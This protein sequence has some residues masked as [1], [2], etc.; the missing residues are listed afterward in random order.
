MDL[1]QL[2]KLRELCKDEAAFERLKQILAA[3]LDSPFVAITQALTQTQQQL[4][5]QQ[6]LARVIGRIRENLE[7]ETIFQIST[8]E[9]CQLLTAD[10][11]AVYRFNPD[12]SGDFVAEYVMPGWSPLVAPEIQK[13]WQDTYLQETKGGRYAQQGTF[14]V[15]NVYQAGL[16]DCHVA[17]LEQFQAKA[18]AIVPIFV[19]Q[20]LWGLLAAYQNSR[21]R[22][23]DLDEVTLLVQLGEQFGIAIQQSELL[24]RLQETQRL[25]HIGN[26]DYDLSSQTLTWSDETYRL[27]GLDPTQPEPSYPEFL[28]R[29]HPDDRPPLLAAM[30][31]AIATGTAYDLDLR[32]I[33]TDSSIRHLAMKGQ[34]F[35]NLAGQVTRLFGA[36]LDIT[37]RKQAEIAVQTLNQ[38]LSKSVVELTAVN[39]ELEAFSYSVS[40]DLR[41]PLR[42][43]NGYSQA[44]LED[45]W[46]RLDEAGQR[47]LQ[48]I[49][50][51]TQRMGELIDDVLILSRITRSDMTFQPVNLS[52]LAQEIWLELQAVNPDRQVNCQIQADVMA[53]GDRTLL[54]VLLL[55]LLDNAWKFTSKRSQAQIEFGTTEDSSGKLLYFVCDN[56]TGFDM[57]Y[58]DKLFGAFQRLH[59]V[60]EFS[61]T[62]IGLATA[63][64]IVHRH[65]GQ[66]WGEGEVDRG[67]TFFFTLAAQ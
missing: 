43:I 10:R 20:T 19:G 1:N 48:R 28:D 64:R 9:I 14:A 50:A 18:F 23:W 44:L 16:M 62:G 58:A 22:E 15:A 8:Q 31:H 60:Q 63:Q 65:G 55:N 61:G 54:K 46:E 45:C 52:E 30:Q 51:A 4:E 39:R 57:T 40:H 36:M 6:A 59:S 53:W 11:V 67:A 38:E 17:L 7:L 21:F 27:L 34:P 25:A 24:V 26:W 2:A 41:A 3:T 47:Y 33:H 66:I 5:R 35:R 42:S 32:L 12:W 56:G 29:V 49:R 13:V 37:E